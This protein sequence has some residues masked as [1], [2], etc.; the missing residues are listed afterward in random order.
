VISKRV[1]NTALA[2]GVYRAWEHRLPAQTRLFDDP[3]IEHLLSGVYGLV[4]R[5]GLARRIA[6]RVLEA[7]APGVCGGVVCRTRAIDEATCEAIAAGA[8]Q[9]VVLGAGMDTRPYRLAQMSGVTVWELDVP[10]VLAAKRA[11]LTRALGRVP[12]N[13]RYLS[14]DLTAGTLA[15]ALAADGFDPDV[16][17]LLLCEGVS[18]YLPRDAV[19]QILAFAGTMAAGSRFVFTYFLQSVFESA[20]LAKAVER[21]EWLS[22]FDPEQLAGLFAERGLDLVEDIGAEDYEKRYLRPRNRSLPVYA[23]ERQAVAEIG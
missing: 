8:T 17:T 12:G 7:Y 18:M 16:Q 13:V 9:I 22:G 1:Q 10:D 14:V 20:R 4:A 3:V 21:Y 11:S 2:V 5:N 19:E 6:A 15:E 23:L